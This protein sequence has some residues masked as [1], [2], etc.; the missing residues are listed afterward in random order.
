MH[1][2][3]GGV[4]D[5]VRAGGDASLRT[6]FERP[7]VRGT[8]EGTTR[9]V[10]ALLYTLPSIRS[11]DALRDL[12]AR[13]LPAGAVDWSVDLEGSHARFDFTST[14]ALA[15]ATAAIPTLAGLP[16]VGQVE[17]AAPGAV[18]PLWHVAGGAEEL[19][20]RFPT[21]VSALDREVLPT[22]AAKNAALRAGTPA[23]RDR[24]LA[25]FLAL[26]ELPFAG[27]PQGVTGGIAVPDEV[28]AG[29]GLAARLAAA[30]HADLRAGGEH[31]G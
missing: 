31:R 7:R 28:S 18:R 29:E 3:G 24:F 8:T 22:L 20:R 5:E 21:Y 6:L 2:G 10:P 17:T 9:P 26:L 15:V 19:I 30:V 25:E 12:L 4:P 23:V 11:L 16:E 13:S 27:A 14:A 1:T